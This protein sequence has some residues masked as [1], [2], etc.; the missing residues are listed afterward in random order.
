MLI[1]RQLDENDGPTLR[2]LRLAA[3]LDAPTAFGRRHEEEVQHPD[4]FWE[5][6]A[7]AQAAGERSIGFF[8]IVD[9]E[10]CGLVGAVDEAEAERVGLFSMWV[11]PEARG[12]GAGRRLAEAVCEWADA[13]QPLVYLWVRDDNAPAIATYRAVGFET[14][15]ETQPSVHRGLREVKMVRKR[16]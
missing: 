4:R 2:R 9:G 13:R 7:R 1:V 15:E 12:S 11:T 14:T 6:R 5:E 16:G 8:A 3:L 10:P